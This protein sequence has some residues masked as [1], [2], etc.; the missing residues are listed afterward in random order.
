M[1]DFCKNL[2]CCVWAMLGLSLVGCVPQGIELPGGTHVV[3]GV[4]YKMIPVEGGT[5]MMG[6]PASDGNAGSDEKPIHKVTL[7][8]FS[9][10]ETEV[11]RELWRAVMGNDQDGDD[12]AYSLDMQAPVRRSRG[13]CLQFI[14]KLNK[15]TGK[16]YRLP[17]EA[18]WEFAAR[19]GNKSKGYVYSGSDNIDDVAWYS[20]NSYVSSSPY[21]VHPV[22]TKLPNE[23][24]IYDMSGNASEWCADGY[25][26]S[27]Y[28]SSPQNNPTGPSAED[29][30]YVTRGGDYNSSSSEC[31][32]AARTNSAH[33]YDCGFRLVLA[34]SFFVITHQAKDVTDSGATLYGEV[35]GNKSVTCGIIYGTSP[36]LSE[37]NGTKI[38]TE[39]EGEFSVT[40]SGLSANTTYYYCAY[41]LIDGVYRYGDIY[42]FRTSKIYTVNGV[43]FNM[44]SVQGGTFTM[45][46]SNYSSNDNYY[47][48]VT[49]DNYAIGETE[50]TQELWRAV[51][52]AN[53]SYYTGNSQQPV[54]SVSW[55]YCQ[56]FIKRLNELTGGGFRLPTEAEWEFAARGG[57]ASKGYTYSGSDS[58]DDVA[59][60]Y[61]NANNPQGVKTKLPNELGIYDMSGNV[62]EWCVDWYNESYYSS[63]PQNNPQGPSTGTYRVCRGGDYSYYSYNYSTIYVK[64]R[65]KLEPNSSAETLGLRL[66]WG[67]LINAPEIVELTDESV[68]L[69]S[70]VMGLAN[71]ETCGF[72]YGT[73]SELSSTT[74]TIVSTTSDGE[75]TVTIEGLEPNTTYYCRAYVVID[76]K[77][78][79]GDVCS[80]NTPF[81]TYT[82]NGIS[83]NMLP[84]QGGTFTMGS[85]EVT[86]SDYAIGETEV[87]Q[88]L[89]KA[90]T[91]ANPSYYTGDLQLPVEYVSWD[92]CQTFIDKLNALT[93]EAFRLPTEAEW[94]FAA[95]G[96]NMSK[97]YTYSGSNTADDVAWY[98]SNSS[99]K[100]HPVKTKLPNELGIYDMS[101]NIAEWCADWYAYSSSTVS[102]L[103][104]PTGPSTGTSRVWRGGS[105][106]DSYSYNEV[107]HRS[108]GSP[109]STYRYTGLRLALGAFVNTGGADLKADGATLYGVVHG[110][111][112][113]VT[114]GV[115]YGTSS[116]LVG[117]TEVSSTFEEVDKVFD[118]DFVV[119]GL[120]PNTTY[121]YSAYIVVDGKYQYGDIRSFKTPAKTYT[122][123]GVSFN[124][125]SVQGGTF[126]MG[127]ETSNS[128]AYGDEKPIHTVTLNNYTIAETEVTQ[129]LWQAV[130]GANPSY[131][132]GDL[133][134]PVEYVSWDDCQTFIS[135]L[136]A[137]TGEAFRLPTE[138]EWEY[139]ARGGNISNDYSY[140][141]SNTI[142]DVAWYTSNASYATHPVKTKLPNELGIYD[143]SGNV[144]EW[145]AD[146]YNS[147]YYSSSSINNPTGPTSGSARVCR[148]GDMNDY[149]TSCRVTCRS[150]AVPTSGSYTIGLRLVR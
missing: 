8:D 37:T 135:K 136:N 111:N 94:E 14:E 18:E 113:S 132:T 48:Q 2:W 108:Y 26:E 146:W 15:K 95:R 42:S 69:K 99:S 35:Y 7:S 51:T 59:W 105:F 25:S 53:P 140:S 124:M 55:E 52:G 109:G 71:S 148:G 129:E 126:M 5:F 60:N 83:F 121:Y 41:M 56:T 123:N 39:A 133:Q 87:T 120:K 127:A 147:T 38:S 114:C 21:P 65:D 74:G 61:N 107:S 110:A 19:G 81:K 134:L 10:G 92:Y 13:E 47:H 68:T 85:A 63:S 117:A 98:S 11:T 66:A 100:T 91:G 12:N 20:S 70:S 77:Y 79:Y 23:L 17:T 112:E 58:R 145:C 106:Y 150:Y 34:P 143:M 130:M 103:H 90:V 149:Q 40:V 9:I 131:Y 137:L 24:G 46:G 31:R 54:E 116:T 144:S 67:F 6:S 36:E 125:I 104:N 73:S 72:I 16:T 43:S 93:G 86:L 82:V 57:N 62:R 49:L 97:G 29:Y 3:K 84:V 27:Y 75:F 102:S 115:V 88:A 45:G 78:I 96:G 22:K 44:I 128:N 76:G 138:A 50:V 28:A 89:W 64:R 32:V 4:E 30:Y 1:R 118:F 122:V 139:A 141:G 119:T 33:Y 80:F 142:D 101:G